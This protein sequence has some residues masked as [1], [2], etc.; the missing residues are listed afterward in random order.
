MG[1]EKNEMIMALIKAKGPLLPVEAAKRI[2]S[3]IYIA[4]AYLATMVSRAEVKISHIKVGGSPLYYLPGQ[5]A[6]LQN[7]ADRLS[8]PEKRIYTLLKEKKVLRESELEPAQ[9]VSL[10][11][12]ND[13]ALPLNV[14][15]EGNIEVFWKWYLLSDEEAEPMIKKL[16]NVEEPAAEKPAA[17][18]EK[19]AQAAPAKVPEPKPE[20]QKPQKKEA[21]EE[22]RELKE[23]KEPKEPRELKEPKEQKETKELKEL[24]EIKEAPKPIPIAKKAE[25]EPVQ[26]PKEAAET[27]EK[28]KKPEKLKQAVLVTEP[29]EKPAPTSVTA[30]SPIPASPAQKEQKPAEPETKDKFLEEVKEYFAANSI[31]VLESAVVKKSTELDL[32]VSVPSAVGRLTYYC[33]AKNKK[34]SNEGDLASAYVQGQSRKLPVLYVSR[35]ELAKKAG[36][37]LGREFKGIVVKTF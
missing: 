13:F 23:P 2:D 29:S 11:A 31:V 25:E 30:P 34:R 26:K 21:V 20:P 19:P 4:S 27:K 15:H 8:A 35:G 14:K 1:Y 7:F 32:V 24:K 5:E 9:R 17:A 3:D 28:R 10:R 6:M 12:L 36:E 16:L 18:P 37:M 22:Q 33:K